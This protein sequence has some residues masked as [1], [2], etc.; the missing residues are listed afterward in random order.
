M[1]DTFESRQLLTVA[2]FLQGTAFDDLNSNGSLDAT[3]SPLAGATINL[4]AASS[5]T[6]LAT[7]TT[8]TDGGYLFNSA[9][10]P[11]G[12]SVGATYSLV[13]SAAGYSNTGAQALSQI[14]PAAVVAPDTIKVTV[15]DPNQVVATFNSPATY[16]T[17]PY[18]TLSYTLNGSP[19]LITPTQL[20]FTLSGA[21]NVNPTTFSALCVGPRDLLSF[22]TPFATVV[23]PQTALPNG[24]QIAYLYNHY[25]LTTLTTASVLPT[26][27]PGLA[28]KNVASG[29]QVAVWELE[30]G[31]SFT[32]TGFDTA[33]TTAQDYADLQTAAAAFLADSVGKSEKLAVL[34]ASLTGTLPAPTATA[35]GQSVLAALSYNFG[36]KQ[37]PLGSLS[38]TV[39]VDGNNN[40]VK[41]GGET[42]L[43]SIPVSLV[44]SAGTVVATTS[45]ASDGSYSFTNLGP[46]TYKLVEGTPRGYLASSTNSGT[47]TGVVVTAGA[48]NPNNNFGQ[49]LPGSIAGVVFLDKTGDGLTGDDA[50][51]A[52]V[53]VQLIGANG[54]VLGSQKVGNNGAYSFTNLAPG[55]YTV[56][57][58]TPSGFVQTAPNSLIYVVPLAS[59]QNVAGDNFA[60][61]QITGSCPISN[62]S[63]SDIGAG[64]TATFSSLGGNTS[65]GDQVTV[66]FTVGGTSPVTVTFVT[67]TATGNFD[68]TKQ[69]V[70]SVD[71]ETLTPGRHSL[72]V[73]IPNSYYQIDFVCGGAISTFN[74]SA[75]I[76]Y[77]GEGRFIDADHG[78]SAAAPTAFAN[79]SGSVFVDNNYD[80]AINPNDSGLGGVAVKLTGKDINGKSVALTRITNKDGSYNFNGLQPGS[81]SVREV[82]PNGYF[83]TKN[84]VGTINGVTV[85]NLSSSSGDTISS[86]TLT[87]GSSAVNYNFGEQVIG[88]ALGCNQTA[89]TCFWNGC[90]GQSLIKSLNGSANST[91]LGNWLAAEFPNSLSCL[92]GKTNAQVAS[93]YQQ[94][95]NYC[96][97]SSLTEGLATAIA[98]YATDSSL[99]GGNYAS[100]S[101]FKVTSA[102]G[103]SQHGEYRQLSRL[104][105]WP[106]RDRDPAATSPVRRQQRQQLRRLVSVPARLPVRLRQRLRQLLTHRHEIDLIDP[107]RGTTDLFPWNEARPFSIHRSSRG[108][109]DGLQSSHGLLALQ[110][111]LAK[112]RER[113]QF[114]GVG[115][116]FGE[117]ADE[118]HRNPGQFRVRLD[119][120]DQVETRR[121]VAI[122]ETVD[123]D[124]I[125][126]TRSERNKSFPLGV[127]RHHLGTIGCLEMPT[128]RPVIVA[129]LTHIENAR[130]GHLPDERTTMKIDRDSV[131]R[132]PEHLLQS[133][134]RSFPAGA[135][136]SPNPV[137]RPGGDRLP[138]PQP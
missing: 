125:E 117:V 64:G 100:C 21:S 113:S 30:Y 48:N 28:P 105:R 15:V 52:G 49:V 137:P 106:A 7:T 103:G 51:Q 27:I 54:A 26:S 6:P 81:Y 42:G 92:A 60:N 68:L 39:Y 122:E 10:V 18:N 62:I 12:L 80:G 108:L 134:D 120:L 85:G 78:G 56:Q 91:K 74:P 87:G 135:T 102:G 94:S 131:G 69:A 99:A 126:T 2:P 41:D 84:S 45:T 33:Y 24:G 17:P 58:V 111:A 79:L 35:G 34:D 40:G 77:H 19:D 59:G 72:T 38:G 88:G 115:L 67:Y 37:I 82:T 138:T 36:N 71:T 50:T 31:S 112:S 22:N 3:E 23:A 9:N 107:D 95:Y 129:T 132:S 20:N 110:V 96:R 116:S 29:L 133:R 66:N 104:L 44:N 136:K 70:F 130:H 5:S 53:T 101:G 14:N 55:T 57:E 4:Y 109:Q 83:T 46:G 32:L 13:E 128:D 97:S 118:H 8:G 86:V 65:Q 93:F 63:Y 98:A 1:M 123:Q 89:S 73:T 127:G 25:G 11:G 121:P 114:L 47:L 61:Y 90:S 16:G 75:N 76:T 43:G 124:Q 119:R